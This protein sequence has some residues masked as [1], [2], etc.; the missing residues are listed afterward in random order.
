MRVLIV[1]ER[2]GVVRRAFASRGHFVVSVDLAPAE[3]GAP[4]GVPASGIGQ[5]YIGDVFDFARSHYGGPVSSAW[6]LMIAHPPCQYLSASGLHWNRRD[7]ARQAKTGEALAFALRLW[8]LPIARIGIE[9]P[10]GRLTA[11]LRGHGVPIQIVQPYQF[12]HDASKATC[13]MLKGLNPLPLDPAHRVRGRFVTCNGKRV[14][15]WAN[16]TDSGQNRLGP[17]DTRSMDR[18]RTYPG[19]AEAMALN[20]G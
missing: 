9:N 15:R 6:D 5:H 1:C 14:E 8:S 19:I 11:Y 13:L 16:Q 3:D 18:A 4:W 7:P 2:S 12:G 20:W 17:S 10:I